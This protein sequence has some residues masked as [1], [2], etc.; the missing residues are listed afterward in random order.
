[1][2]TLCELHSSHKR[3]KWSPSLSIYLFCTIS[4]YL[5][6]PDSL[7]AQLE[8]VFLPQIQQLSSVWLGNRSL[9]LNKIQLV[10]MCKFP[11]PFRLCGMLR[12]LCAAKRCSNI[13]QNQN[14]A[15]S[16]GNKVDSKPESELERK[17]TREQPQQ[18]QQ[19]VCNL[20]SFN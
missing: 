18:Q 4:P 11:F 13:S 12:S 6:L 16:L 2:T 5:S 7:Q 9:A 15:F 14:K 20:M 1:M 8:L 19:F 3:A 17:R 10:N